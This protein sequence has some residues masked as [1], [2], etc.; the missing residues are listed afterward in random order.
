[1][2]EAELEIYEKTKLP[3][4]ERY[5]IPLMWCLRILNSCK[6]VEMMD[7][8]PY[9]EAV[10]EVLKIKESIQKL[11]QFAWVSLPLVYTQVS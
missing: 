2:T 1:M 3:E 7:V 10:K 9:R 4:R 8:L 11:Q 6:K 5:V